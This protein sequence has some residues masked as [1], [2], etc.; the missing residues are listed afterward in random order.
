MRGET[1]FKAAVLSLSD[2]RK[3]VHDALELFDDL[4]RDF[5]RL[6]ETRPDALRRFWPPRLRVPKRVLARPMW[7][8]CGQRNFD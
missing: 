8:N 5:A 3:C 2:G 4:H 6:F 7:S 1:V